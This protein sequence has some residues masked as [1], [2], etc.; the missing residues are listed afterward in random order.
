MLKNVTLEMSLKPFRQTDDAYID[1]VIRKIFMDWS[2]LIGDAPCVSVML[3]T[4]DGSEILE[5]KGDLNEKME[6]CRYVGG[7]NNLEDK[8]RNRKFDPDGIGLHSRAYYYMDNPPEFTY[9][10]LK[11]IIQRIKEIGSEMYPGRTI[12]VGET[13]DPGPEFAV[14]EFK[15]RKHNEICLA[16]TMRKG[17]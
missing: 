11:K 3:W 4:A 17:S 6:W 12:R 14:S 13:F 15:Y 16:N 5:W 1:S 9:G 2:I 8:T 10:L 7:A